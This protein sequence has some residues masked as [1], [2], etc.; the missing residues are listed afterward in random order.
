[1]IAIFRSLLSLGFSF[2]F[3][4]SPFSLQSSPNLFKL[5]LQLLNRAFRVVSGVGV[6][7][8]DF[9][10]KATIDNPARL[11]LSATGFVKKLANGL[12]KSHFGNR[13]H[14]FLFAPSFVCSA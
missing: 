6:D 4:R 11:A 1:M 2:L 7:Y 8:F 13:C 9:N 14:A 10:A 5:A 12:V 3:S